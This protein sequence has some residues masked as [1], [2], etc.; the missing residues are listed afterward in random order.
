MCSKVKGFWKCI[1]IGRE[2]RYCW[3]LWIGAKEQAS[4][5][6]SG[7]SSW[8]VKAVVS[9]TNVGESKWE[10]E[11]VPWVAGEALL[12]LRKGP[13][14]GSMDITK[15]GRKSEVNESLAFEFW[16]FWVLIFIYDFFW[17]SR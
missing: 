3:I 8:V 15:R 7:A 4:V 6:K 12:R 16:F 13:A 9:I 14:M 1:G 11:V 5:T 10:L 2:I 17:V